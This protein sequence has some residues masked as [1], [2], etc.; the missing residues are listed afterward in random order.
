[1]EYT[2]SYQ[3]QIKIIQGVGIPFFNTYPGTK[4]GNY[5]KE[6]FLG[7]ITWVN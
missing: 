2:Y 1:M 4:N 7:P 5:S 6:W 3:V